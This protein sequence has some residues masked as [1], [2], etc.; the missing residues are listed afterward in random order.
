MHTDELG[1]ARRSAAL[2]MAV[3]VLVGACGVAT[4]VTATFGAAWSGAFA[5]L[6]ALPLGGVVAYRAWRWSLC[7][8]LD[9]AGSSLPS[10]AALVAVGAHDDRRARNTVS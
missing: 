9:G 3:A 2:V 4:W 10:A 8:P 6:V 5:L 7:R 1:R